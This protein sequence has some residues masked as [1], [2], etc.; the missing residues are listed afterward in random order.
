M[1]VLTRPPASRHV[2]RPQAVPLGLTYRDPDGVEWVVGNR[3]PYGIGAYA[4]AGISGPPVSLA[5]A[6]LP[7]GGAIPLSYQPTPRTIT[8]GVHV[9]GVDQDDFL[10]LVDRWAVAI[11][12]ERNGRP[13]SGTFI[14][15]RPDGSS[16]QIDVLCIDG[17]DQGDDD[18]TKSGPT[19]TTYTLTF[20]A[21]DPLWSDAEPR[22][23]RFGASS[24]VGV[25][26]MPPIRLAPATLLGDT[27]ITNSGSADAY[28]VWAITGPGQPT[29]INNTTGR[30]WGLDVVLDDEETVTVDTD[31]SDPTAIDQDGNNRWTDL[32]KTSPRDLWPLVRGINEVSLLMS[33]SGAGS[34]I[35]LEYTRR[36]LRA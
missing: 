26:A 33:G 7:G 23:L 2:L 15:G 17:P 6:A 16:R 30:A 35:V 19:W 31:P 3:K 24:A 13:A 34:Q 18:G 32:V 5:S 14:V 29:L 1:P 9:R 25:P 21:T 12:N 22:T 11:Y 27:R 10:D 36:W 20:T 28:G 4:C 8:L